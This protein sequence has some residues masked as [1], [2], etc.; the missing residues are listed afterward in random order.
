VALTL[1]QAMTETHPLAEGRL[2][3]GAII[4]TTRFDWSTLQ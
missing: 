3:L 1:K 2:T 4:D